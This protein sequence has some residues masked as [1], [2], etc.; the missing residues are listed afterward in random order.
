MLQH[1]FKICTISNNPKRYAEMK[2]LF[3]YVE[4]GA[5]NPSA[6]VST[7]MAFPHKVLAKVPAF[8]TEPSLGAL[9]FC[10]E[11]LN[12]EKFGLVKRSLGTAGANG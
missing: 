5:D 3:L 2:S 10:D 9:C 11:T 12:Y 7:N 4:S 6:F 1:I 8:D